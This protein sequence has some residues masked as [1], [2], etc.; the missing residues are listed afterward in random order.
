MADKPSV[1]LPGKVEKIIESPHSDLP[2]KA[3]IEV[4]GADDLYKEIRIDNTLTDENG[5][6]VKLKEGAP[7]EVT[8]EAK[9][10]ATTP[11]A[12]EKADKSTS[13]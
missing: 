3:E 10:E 12:E 6:E 4:H 5:K 8:V 11:K 2:E 9:P 1:T 7:V 13:K